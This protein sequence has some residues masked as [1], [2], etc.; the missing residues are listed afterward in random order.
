MGVM[1]R[2]LASASE[3]RDWIVGWFWCEPSRRRTLDSG[4]P[5]CSAALTAVDREVGR[6]RRIFVSAV[7]RA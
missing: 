7:F 1:G 5:T 6:A 2:L 4:M 3:M